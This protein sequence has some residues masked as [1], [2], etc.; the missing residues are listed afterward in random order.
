MEP[1]TKHKNCSV[2]ILL[3]STR[4]SSILPFLFALWLAL[5]LQTIQ[6][7]LCKRKL[8]LHLWTV[9]IELLQ[10]CIIAGAIILF[11][12]DLRKQL[13]LN[14]FQEFLS[15]LQVVERAAAGLSHTEQCA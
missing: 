12:C 7:M 15:L 6:R 4:I 5:W 2:I 10:E 9:R 14:A 8:A 1:T 13:L 3:T 11:I